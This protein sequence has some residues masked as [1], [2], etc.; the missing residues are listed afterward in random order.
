MGSA[1]KVLDSAS[2]ALTSASDVDPIRGNLELFLGERMY[3]TLGTFMRP[4][5]GDGP[6]DCPRNRCNSSALS[7][8]PPYDSR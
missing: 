7:R 1:P 6:Q 2:R 8:Q 5:S 3:W 4:D